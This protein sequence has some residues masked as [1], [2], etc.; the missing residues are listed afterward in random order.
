M[1]RIYRNIGSRNH[2]IA[3]QPKDEPAPET[4]PLY[5]V[6]AFG[7]NNHGAL[8]VGYNTPYSAIQSPD[9]AFTEITDGI[10]DLS[11]GYGNTC[12]ID[13]TGNLWYAG[14][15]PVGIEG[16]FLVP[17]KS[18]TIT[19]VKKIAAEHQGYGLLMLKEDGTVWYVGWEGDGYERVGV[20]PPSD[21]VETQIP[22]LTDI[23]AVK[24]ASYGCLALKSNGDLYSWASNSYGQ[25]GNNDSSW[26][27]IAVPTLILSDVKEIASGNDGYMALKNNGD[28]YA[29]GINYQGQT[30]LPYTDDD[31]IYLPTL[32]ASNVKK[33]SM[34]ETHSLYMANDGT[35]YGTGNPY[36]GALGNGITTIPVDQRD[37]PE[38]DIYFHWISTGFPSDLEGISAGSSNSFG[39]KGNTVYACGNYGQ[40]G[41]LGDGRSYTAPNNYEPNVISYTVSKPVARI[42]SE[43]DNGQIYLMYKI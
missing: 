28:L 2:Y 25:G 30:G 10:L 4:V 23:I 38:E 13:S 19:G 39:W 33:M 42:E 14:Q 32:T 15:D 24:M 17:L 22:D 3:A 36:T 43:N 6:Q 12:V 16:E 31:G 37:N 29:W 1:L 40:Y 11:G 18:T 41:S 7:S 5:T 8:G 35:V 21:D 34:G 26:T 9:N 20:V 27:S